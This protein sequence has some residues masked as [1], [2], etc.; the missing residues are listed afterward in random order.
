MATKEI[1]Y[2]RKQR[3]LGEVQVCLKLA[4]DLHKAMPWNP[5]LA[6]A[7][8]YLLQVKQGLFRKVLDMENARDGEALTFCKYQVD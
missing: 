7:V 1:A 5:D 3:E 4:I 2:R 6:H 8:R